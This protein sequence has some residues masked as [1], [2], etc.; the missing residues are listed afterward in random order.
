TCAPTLASCHGAID[1]D[2][3]SVTGQRVRRG[4]AVVTVSAGVLCACSPRSPSSGSSVIRYQQPASI[5]ITTDTA[6]TH[7]GNHVHGPRVRADTPVMSAFWPF[8]TSLIA[9]TPFQGR[10]WNAR[11]RR[12]RTARR[13]GQAVS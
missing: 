5:D 2:A 12:A 9:A 1:P 13:H 7:D 11:C 10:G 8:A 3:V 6:A 4:V